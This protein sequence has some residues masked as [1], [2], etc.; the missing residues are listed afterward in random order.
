MKYAGLIGYPVAH[1][2]S[3]QMHHAGFEALG[4]EARYE[5]WETPAGEL[6]ARVRSLRAP[7]ML[8]ANVTIPH[9]EAVLPWLD[10]CDPQAERIGAVNTIVN[11][12]GRLLGY[13]TDAPGFLRALR[14]HMGP[15]FDPRG[16]QV[17]LL[18]N[19]GAARGAAIALLDSAVGTLTVLARNEAHTEAL[20]E[21]LRGRSSETPCLRGARF[22]TPEARRALS[23]ADVVVNTT[24]VGLK[25]GD[26]TLLIDVELVPRSAL[27]M[28]MIFNPPRTPLLRAAEVR[29]CSV[30][31]GLSMLLYQGTLAFELWMGRPAPEDAMRAALGLE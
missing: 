22:D 8:G 15:G 20:L 18:G 12:N 4:V 26:E 11:R 5:L 21:H 24:S 30:L 6:E 3:P 14:E 28:D 25:P 16:K 29:G 19:G 31:N 17:V 23:E 7:E 13:N 9:K 1:S 27:V 2:L 10:E